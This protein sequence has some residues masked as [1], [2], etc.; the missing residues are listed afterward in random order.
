MRFPTEK[1][2]LL[3]KSQKLCILSVVVLVEWLATA[4]MFPFTDRSANTGRSVNVCGKA[5]QDEKD[6]RS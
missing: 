6:R 5:E 2:F 4:I 3:D 1:N